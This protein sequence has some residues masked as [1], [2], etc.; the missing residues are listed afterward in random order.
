MDNMICTFGLTV[1]DYIL[2]NN[3]DHRTD[4]SQSNSKQIFKNDTTTCIKKLLII[5]PNW[6]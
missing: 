5:D 2:Y 6:L 3:I 1:D 4:I